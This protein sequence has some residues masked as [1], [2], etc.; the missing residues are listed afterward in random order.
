MRLLIGT[1]QGSTGP[2]DI[3]TLSLLETNLDDFNPQFYEPVIGHLFEAGAV[4]VYLSPIQM[5]KN[6]LEPIERALPSARSE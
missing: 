4:D 2:A 1:A 5:K 3:E 6:R